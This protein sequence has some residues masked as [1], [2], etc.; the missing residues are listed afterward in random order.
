MSTQKTAIPDR[1]EQANR[2]DFYRY[3]GM[4]V[5]SVEEEEGMVELLARDRHHT[6]HSVRAEGL[7]EAM[8]KMEARL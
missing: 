7:R 4:M 8:K 1:W 2:P 5:K 6:R 3:K